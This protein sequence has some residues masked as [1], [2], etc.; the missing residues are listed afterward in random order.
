[1]AFGRQV[2]HRVGIVLSKDA[3]AALSQIST[4]SN[5][6]R[7][8]SDAAERRQIRSVGE[9]VDVEDEQSVSWRR[10]RTTAEPIKPAP[11]VT[12]SVSPP[13]FPGHEIC[14]QHAKTLQ[15]RTRLTVDRPMSDSI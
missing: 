13:I 14:T 2:Q 8:I 7:M 9:L 1:M 12:E 10:C 5:R 4:C 15:F 11:P 3:R 6:S